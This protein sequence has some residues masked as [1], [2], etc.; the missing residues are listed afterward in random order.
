MQITATYVQQ[1]IMR[2]HHDPASA[3]DAAKYLE[4]R[5]C[6]PLTVHSYY[7]R[8]ASLGYEPAMLKVA[9]L[10]MLGECLTSSD[11]D[12]IPRREQ[13]RDLAF[14]LIY[15]VATKGSD[16]KSKQVALY[17]LARCYVDGF[18]T[19]ISPVRAEYY[20]SQVSQP[21][22]YE[23]YRIQESATFGA[24]SK[25]MRLLVEK[26]WKTRQILVS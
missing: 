8:S 5:H 7:R 10:L 19:D 26:V 1:L 22:D 25:A 11:D 13:N 15:L 6:S 23:I 9:G 24:T 2:A 3:Y 16:P 4:S 14:K 17:L 21:R 12:I 20:L 18:G